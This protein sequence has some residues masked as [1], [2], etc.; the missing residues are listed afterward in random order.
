MLNPYEE[1][2]RLLNLPNDRLQRNAIHYYETGK[3]VPGLDVLLRYS[4]LSGLT[5]DQ[6]A[7]DRADLSKKLF[8]V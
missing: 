6:L 1:M 8:G 2:L 7:D 5:I 4:E 3:R